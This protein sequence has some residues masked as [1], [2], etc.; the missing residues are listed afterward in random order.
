MDIIR[1]GYTPPSRKGIAGSL[2]GKVYGEL[3]GDMK[4]EAVSGKTATLVE[5]GWS[6]S[7]N[8]PV[9]ASC[10][11]VKNNVYFLDSHD[12]GS[13]TKSAEYCTVWCLVFIQKA[14]DEFNY[15]VKGVVTDNARSMEKMRMDLLEQDSDLIVYGCSAHR[16]QLLGRDCHHQA[17]HRGT[18]VFQ[19]PPQTP[20]LTQ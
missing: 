6:N 2:L 14:K 4:E 16:L 9:I 10:L 19:E 1:P 18:E 13:M 8:E 5:N 17:H 3:R 11:Q 7:H 15:D 12:T 20:S